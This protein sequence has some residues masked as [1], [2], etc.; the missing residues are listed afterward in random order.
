M[1]CNVL[2]IKK[3]RKGIFMNHIYK[4]I[5][6]K[7]KHAYIVVSEL[8]KRDG[9]ASSTTRGSKKGYAAALALAVML[10]LSSMGSTA[11]AS[12]AVGGGTAGGQS[13]VAIGG[14]DQANTYARQQNSIA[15]GNA[16]IANGVNAVSIGD[17]ANT[18]GGGG[19]IAIGLGAYT[20]TDRSSPTSA[21][22]STAITA[23]S[24]GSQSHSAS[25]AAIALGSRTSAVGKDSVAIGGDEDGT[26][27][28]GPTSGV[29]GASTN[30]EGAIAL[31]AGSSASLTKNTAIGYLAKATITNSVALGA[32]STTTVPNTGATAT[33]IAFGNTTYTYAGSP[34]AAKGVVS[35]GTS[36]SQRQLQN[37]AAGNIA[38]D[39]TDAVN[40]SQLYAVDTEVQKG[41]TFAGDSGTH[42]SKLG[43]TLNINGGNGT[44]TFSTSNVKTAMTTDTTN[45][46]GTLQIQFS[47]TPT[48]TSATIGGIGVSSTGITM[49]SQKITGLADGTGATDAVTY[50]QL[51]SLSNA[52]DTGWT[53]TI[54]GGT[55]LSDGTNTITVGT[56]DKFDVKGQNGITVSQTGTTSGITIDASSITSGNAI[57]YVKS[58]SATQTEAN[59]SGTDSAALGWQSVASGTSSTA[60]GVSAQATEAG[61]TSVGY[62]AVSAGGIAI[63]YNAN[64]S[65]GIAIGRNAVANAGEGLTIGNLEQGMNQGATGYES[66]SVGNQAAASDVLGTALG[67]YANASGNS[68]TALG[69]SSKASGRFSVA[70]GGAAEAT[71]ENAVSVGTVAKIGGS[72]STG[73]GTNASITADNGTVVGEGTNVSAAN[74]TALGTGANAS[75]VNSVALGAN[76]TTGAV[77]T[78]TI[79]DAT[80]ITKGTTETAYVSSDGTVYNYAGLASDANGTVS[81]GS[82]GAERQIQNVAAGNIT[83]TST[84]A[85]NGSQLYATNQ[86]IATLG[87]QVNTGWKLAASTDGGTASGSTP[88]SVTPDNNTL[89]VKAGKGISLTS[90]NTTNSLTITTDATAIDLSTTNAVLY[91]DTGKT[92]ITLQGAGGTT[93]TNVATGTLSAASTDA[94]NGS[95]LYATNQKVDQNTTNITNITTSVNGG[96]EADVNGTKLKDVTPAS[97]NLNFKAGSNVTVT[98]TGNDI[99]IA[100]NLSNLDPT[101]TNAVVYDNTEKTAVTLGGVGSTTPVT[102]TNVKAGDINAASTDVV[103]G[104]QLFTTNQNVTNITN[105]INAGWEADVNGTKAKDVTPT[106][107]KLNFKQGSNVT[108]TN[109][110]DDITIAAN[111]SALDP[112]TTN[113]VVYDGTDKKTV[114]L[115]GA[116]GTKLT[117]V[118]AGDLS[119]TSTDAINGSQLYATN[120]SITNITT[121]VNGGWEADVNGTKLKDVTPASKNLNFKAGSNVTVTGTG[122]DITI[123]AD[124]SNLDPTTTNAVVYDN[125]AKTAVT[126]GGVGSTTPVTLTNVKAGDLSAASTDAV[127]GSQLY[128][129]NQTVTNMATT[130]N[131]GWEADVNGT[132]AKDVTPTNKKLNFKQGSNVTI[133]NS[134]DDITIAANLS[135]LDP[136]TTNAVVYDGTDKKTVTLSGAGGTK[137]TNVTAGDL[138][139]TSTD[140]INGSQLYATNQSITNITNSVNGGWEADVNGTKL[141]DVTPTS[142]NLNFKAGSNVT[143]TGT[144]NDITI[145][146]NLSN[147]DPTTT[148]AVVYDNTAKTAVTLGG[149]G[150]TTPVTLTNVKAGDLS[151]ASTDAVNGSQLFTTNQNVTN[152][153][154]T[155]NAGW[156]AD[157]NGTK[158]KDVTPTNKKLNFKQGSN[159][160]ITNSGDDITI[161]ANLSALDPTTTNAVVYDGT[162]KKTV[163]LSG[164]GG[165]KLTNVTAGDLSATSTDAI[166]GSQLYAT[167]Q[168]ITNI[169]NSVNGGWE[170]DVNG[171]KLK[172]VTP[173][174]KNLNFKAGSNVT[175]TGTGNDITI[176]ADLSN[177]DPTTTNAVVY[178]NTAKTAVTLGG[179]GT[180]TPV[181][182]TNVKAGDLSAA[183]TDA[184]N[185]SQLFTTNQKVDQN[186]TNITNITTSVNGG[187]E[188]DVNG[189]KLKDVTPASKN[190]NFKSGKN[191][192]VSGAGNDITIA[193]DLTTI[194]S[195]SN[196]VLYDNTAKTAVTLGGVGTT[197][198]IALTNVKA[199]DLSATS[200]DAVNG[201]QLFTTNQNVTN[202][203][204]TMNAGWE[205]DVN[206]TKAKDVTPSNKKLNF[207]QGS[208]VTITN[209]GD[210]ITIAADLSALDPTT[211]NAVV[212]DG[213][214][215]KTVTL[216]GFGGTKLT[217]VTAGDLSATSTDAING[218]QLYATNQSITNI[219]NSVNGGWEADV[220]GTK[221]KDVTPASKNLNFKAGSNVTVTGTGNDI[222]IA[223]DLSN[224]DPTTTNAV[225]Y[226]NTAKTAVT[227]GGVGTTTSVALHNV[228]AGIEGT[229]AVNMDQLTAATTSITNK[230]LTFQ[231]NTTSQVTKKLGETMQI[232]GAGQKADSEYSAENIKTM[233]D[234]NGNLVVMMDKNV[235]STNIQVGTPGTNGKNGTPGSIG[236]IGKAGADGTNATATVTVEPGTPGVN[237]TNGET[238]TRIVYADEA[239]TKHETATLD[240]GLKFMGD[241]GLVAGV[242]LNKQINFLGGADATNLSDGNIGVVS[243]AVDGEGNETLNVKLA[244]NLQGLTSVSTDTLNVGNT[245]TINKDGIDAGDTKITNLKDGTET[246]DAATVGQVQQAV[247][248]LA[249]GGLNLAGNTGNSRVALGKTIKVIGDSSVTSPD[250]SVYS[251]KNLAT[252]ETEDAD[253]NGI[254]TI[255]LKDKP[256]FSQVTAG[257]QDNTKVIIGDGG[258]SVGGK[259][260]INENGLNANSLKI[261]NVKTGTDGTDAVNVNQLNEVKQA[262]AAAKSTVSNKDNNL[263]VTTSTATDG[264]T[265]YNVDLADKVTIGTANPVT[266]DGTKGTVTGL[267]NTTW[268]TGSYV[269]GRAA[270][271]DQLQTVAT[272]AAEAAKNSDTHI[273]FGEYSADSSGKVTMDVVNNVTN[274]KTGTV[275]ITDVASKAQQDKNT[276]AI[277]N[278]WNAQINGATVKNVTPANNNLNF[279]AGDNVSITND[280]GAIKIS[281]SGNDSQAVHYDS[282]AKDKVTLGGSDGTTITNVKDGEVSAT[283]KDAVNGSQLYAVE[284]KIGEGY[285]ESITKLG[286]GLSEL[287]NR[288]NKVGA[289]A[290]AL[291]ALHPLDFDPDDK[292]DFAAGYGRYNGAS[293]ASVGAFYRPNEDTMFSVG[294]SVGNGENMIN[295]GVSVKLGQGNHVT[296]SR[297][298]MAKEIVQLKKENADMKADNSTMR[299]ELEEI[300]AQMA[301]LM[302]AKEAK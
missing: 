100:A 273:K 191:V 209:S 62:K 205:A 24:I 169:T 269:S 203:T 66:L 156:E 218:S 11:L 76:S 120:Q 189:T 67:Y 250:T 26:T 51:T 75:T 272:Q 79:N 65:D 284:Q 47:T 171:T 229:D 14:V 236:L 201:S 188:A 59:V 149:V 113:A 276:A 139:A 178:D 247:S 241:N 16:S 140:A 158:A 289:G 125:T 248:E 234:A 18:N 263:K 35:I 238:M 185:G 43:T 222:T 186:T 141:K 161:A 42:N 50:G 192:T 115:S 246:T 32:A 5:W 268:S 13:A 175:V 251:S 85:V 293:A 145:A 37:V 22:T 193:A 260:Y 225:V 301:Q 46:V 196:A 110:G 127:N 83:A 123:A 183:S 290:A 159:V 287:D 160:T 15:I 130:V 137:L 259:T 86:D 266:I 210:D 223:A 57:K 245:V 219:T 81:V 60:V 94:V 99:T 217:N 206:G 30:G 242:K 232:V 274:D 230:G 283:S 58:N 295:A 98:G 170:A 61:A 97:K 299:Q 147:L 114:T 21:V 214:D 176:A 190:L 71:G 84:D 298:A 162:D 101:T 278:G 119:A 69:A 49:N 239:G 4:V 231:G 221:L 19:D 73:V 91:D 198:P 106:N 208:N 174:S 38:T 226:D 28:W 296:T 181:T 3:R 240:D 105:T 132:K 144:G 45:G 227:L 74:A 52:V 220:N 277:N 179:V 200:T 95:Q 288:I 173:T 111:L 212:Y 265:N 194:D 243:T 150:S 138:S 142:K 31:G 233:V 224:L 48:F 136:T 129:T 204:N 55:N 151:A 20:G 41:T 27:G 6:S 17:D 143:V 195:T 92:K 285:G 228:K 211:T 215:K 122:N 148:N 88:I 108:I 291:A 235:S 33:S 54:N 256:E 93:L 29:G 199:G 68:A 126:L 172:D 187:W 244:K 249:A 177:L 252:V 267:T 164:A 146:A 154:N 104:S 12:Y 116:G 280:N 103:N 36:T 292:W 90:D 23:I 157:V 78:G 168:S 261:T 53:P 197:T 109:S 133:T 1:L 8:A 270:T 271:E 165:T 258:V 216:G 102:L 254:I 44:G 286:Q 80:D 163:T 124:L 237:G 253:G 182:L 63:G 72:N 87:T 297:V 135:A 255:E 118:T 112:T 117:N 128:A 294:A 300:K 25:T 70:V 202:I 34:T 131:S 302:K 155:M 207:K 275:T 40:G 2:M 64:T 167:N 264:S 282:A 89:N 279:V 7:T 213:T 152:I 121:S 96:W 257:S 262:A 107:K 39:S 77:N 134:G 9:K 180:T 281:G 10:S 153:T 184:V 166:N 56:G 82:A